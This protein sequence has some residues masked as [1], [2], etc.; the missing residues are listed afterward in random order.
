MGSMT[1]HQW[2]C[3]RKTVALLILGFL[4][5]LPAVPSAEPVVTVLRGGAADVSG[6][7]LEDLARIWRRSNKPSGH[8]LAAREVAELPR[9]L[10]ILERGRAH[11]AILD[12]ASAIR[13]LGE[14]LN[15]A[16]VGLLWPNYLHALGRG[17]GSPTLGLPLRERLDIAQSAGYVFTG[18]SEWAEGRAGQAELLKQLEAGEAPPLLAGDGDGVMLYSAPAP[19][20]E[21]LQ[22]LESRPDLHLLRFSNR[23]MEE[24]KLLYPWLLSETLPKGSYPGMT[25]DWIMPAWRPVMV[26]RRDLEPVIV[27]KMVRTLYRSNPALKKANPL[28]RVLDSKVNEAFSK[29][30]PFHPVAAKAYNFQSTKP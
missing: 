16:A 1:S 24:L 19:W 4:L 15:L 13:I 6:W 18:L 28:F 17:T 21:T 29:L 14:H 10:R 9:R 2:S 12:A 25:R 20:D 30:L 5:V 22:L 3:L 11:F 7:F 27:Q 26:G 8:R 23:F